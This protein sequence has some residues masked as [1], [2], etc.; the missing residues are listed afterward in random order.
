M[1]PPGLAFTPTNWS[2]AQNVAIIGVNDD[3]VDDNINYTILT[4]KVISGDSSYNDIDPSDISVTNLDNDGTSD[5][6]DT[7]DTS[8]PQAEGGTGDSNC[9]INSVLY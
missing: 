2:N 8:P 1:T 3:I 5:S 7:G 6:P 4:H 9:F